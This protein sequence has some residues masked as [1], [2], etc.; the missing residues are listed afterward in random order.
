MIQTQGEMKTKCNE[1]SWI[2]CQDGKKELVEQLVNLNKMSRLVN[3]IV[4]ILHS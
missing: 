2:G 1:E 4:S 3:S